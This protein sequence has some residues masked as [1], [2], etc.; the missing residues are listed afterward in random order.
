MAKTRKIKQETIDEEVSFG[1]PKSLNTE[2]NL[3]DFDNIA[4]A[5]QN[6]NSEPLETSQDVSKRAFTF[7][8]QTKKA[9]QFYALANHFQ[10]EVFKECFC[11]ASQPFFFT[12]VLKVFKEDLEAKD[13]YKKAPA[14]FI[15]S[16]T[17]KGKRKQTNRST[18]AE[19]K[20]YL[21][22]NLSEEIF[23]VY[24]DIMFSYIRQNPDLDPTVFTTS[25]FIHDVI[26]YAEKHQEIIIERGIK[27]I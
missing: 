5:N 1:A 23:D 21:Y 9:A 15:E 4:K 27:D 8:L 2:S 24:F 22:I 10:I 25:Y 14:K 13:A 17:R 7:A 3:P 18:S 20:T 11:K 26:N 6:F 12:T 19:D 16:V